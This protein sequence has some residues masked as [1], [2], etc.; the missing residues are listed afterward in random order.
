MG[1]SGECVVGRKVDRVKREYQMDTT[2][3]DSCLA[4]EEKKAERCCR[5]GTHFEADVQFD[6]KDLLL[7][8]MIVLPTTGCSA[9]IISARRLHEKF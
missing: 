8:E 7:G 2:R 3:S 4:Y 5:G 6:C 1:G 9:F